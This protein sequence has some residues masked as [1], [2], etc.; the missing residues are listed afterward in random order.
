MF[1]I[2]ILLVIFTLTAKNYQNITLAY[3][4][5]RGGFV[6]N[7][8]CNDTSDV[9]LQRRFSTNATLPVRPNNVLIISCCQCE[10][11]IFSQTM[12]RRAWSVM[13]RHTHN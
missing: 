6:L 2:P 11:N 4:K 1:G 5:R 9:V 12:V 8:Y 13:S 7:C 10:L 3:S